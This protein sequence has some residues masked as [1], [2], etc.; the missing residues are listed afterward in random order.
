MYIQKFLSQVCD[1]ERENVPAWTRELN[2]QGYKKIMI[3]HACSCGLA[4][5]DSNAINLDICTR[6][7][8]SAPTT[9]IK[10]PCIESTLHQHIFYS[11]LICEQCM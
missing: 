10:M 1:W 2:N 4:A 3:N 9:Y 7:L 8:K 5:N 6:L 11:R